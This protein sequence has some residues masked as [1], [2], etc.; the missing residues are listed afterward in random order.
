MAPTSPFNW[1][2]DAGLTLDEIQ[3]VPYLEAP[4]LEAPATRPAAR[5]PIEA[6]ML[7][8]NARDAAIRGD[9]ARAIETLE[10]AVA[11]DPDRYQLR[12]EL[13]VAYADTGK[14]DDQALASFEAAE[15]L[16]PDT[17]EVQLELGRIHLNQKKDSVALKHLRL[18]T[19]T[20]DYATNDAKAALVDFFLAE[21]LKSLGYDRASLNQYTRLLDRLN[22][23]TAALEQSPELGY[24]RTQREA[25]LEQ[26][27][28]L[29]E[30]HGEFATALKAFMPAVE[31]EPDNMELQARFARDL[32]LDHQREAALNKAV[33]LVVRTRAAPLSLQA[34]RDVCQILKIENG[35]V[36]ELRKLN[37]MHPEDH[38]VLFALS[39]TLESK[40]RVTEA[41]DVLQS[42]WQ[43]SPGDISITRRLFQL[44]RQQDQV[45][46]AAAVL[47]HALAS[48]PSA[49]ENYYPLWI[50]LLRPGQDNHLTMVSLRLLQ[51]PQ[52]DEAARQV[53]IAITA[54]DESRLLFQSTSL[55]KATWQTPPFAPAFRLL[56]QSTLDQR[57]MTDVQK[58]EIAQRLILTAAASGDGALAAELSGRLLASRHNF[59]AAHRAFNQAI[60]I[61]SESPELFVAA[62]QTDRA[63]GDTASF[64]KRLWKV[65]ADTP[66]FEPAYQALYAWY[67]D[68]AQLMPEKA[69]R[70]VSLWRQNDPQ[71]INGR[72]LQ[73]SEH[74][75]A[76]RNAEAELI[77]TGLFADDF[78]AP[79]VFAAMVRFYKRGDRLNDLIRKMEIVQANQPR[80]IDLVARLCT[81]YA[82]QNRKSEAVRLLEATRSRV[83]DDA[84]R[85]Y[86]L[87]DPY[88]AMDQKA[89][90][91]DVLR[92]VI[93]AD[94]MQAGACNGLG[95]E[96]AD[97]GKN[98]PQ[99][100]ALIRVA[101][102]REPDNMRYLD[103][104]GWVLYKRGKLE[105]SL[106]CLQQAVSPM[107]SPNAVVMDHLGDVMYRMS[108]PE[109]AIRVWEQ[110]LAGL[111]DDHADQRKLRLLLF[112]KIKQ[113]RANQPVD[114]P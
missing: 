36:G 102:A 98:L 113:A 9:S 12:Y 37:V 19:Q 114:V 92:Q 106:N 61:G 73:A 105:D 84:D 8:T 15:K 112:Q 86:A 5:P 72:L 39:D 20:S 63:I 2:G 67:T 45:Q 38:A 22:N 48:N 7:Y 69:A 29:L 49:L 83:A 28:E 68:P 95:F 42:A 43:K 97:E 50:E 85:L 62:A 76:G 18:A 66:F 81:L 34:L 74:L 53:W 64:E 78:E 32:A 11:L 107:A 87:V 75:A 35:V 79:G 21:V 94:P 46:A 23:A 59:A 108:R 4:H 80:D 25:I 60:K 26:M 17:I 16:Q 93:A 30:K 44:D 3:P 96:W 54:E 40:Q 33:G 14:Q 71:S 27:G 104:L 13:G 55:E 41:W 24:L 77:Y 57:E 90:A 47:I 1:T 100:E 70:V 31:R 82:D 109:E 89:T 52:D 99:A 110:S 101:L 10:H 103:S 6:L 88:I 56:L 58:N 91:E 65:T 111:A 51:L